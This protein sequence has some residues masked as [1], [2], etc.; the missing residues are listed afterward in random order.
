LTARQKDL[1]TTGIPWARNVA[2]P[3]R[4]L[5]NGTAFTVHVAITNYASNQYPQSTEEN[6]SMHN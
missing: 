6:F 2:R 4:Y 1:E 5:W 3:V